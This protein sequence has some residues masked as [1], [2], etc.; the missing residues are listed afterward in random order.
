M[1]TKDII[2]AGKTKKPED[3]KKPNHPVSEK[4]EYTLSTGYTVHAAFIENIPYK[5][6]KGIATMD[7][8]EGQDALFQAVMSE[9]DFA[10]FD[11]N[12]L[13]GELM[14]FLERWQEESATTLGEL[15][16]S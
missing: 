15:G 11:E 3:K 10:I 12:V 6:F 9:E 5:V 2:A 1:A 14:E 13:M 16:A 7:A 8:A 4:F